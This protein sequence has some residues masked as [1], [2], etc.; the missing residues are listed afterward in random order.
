M[1][2]A[3]H[4][5]KRISHSEALR[6]MYEAVRHSTDGLLSLLGIAILIACG[7]LPEPEN[8]RFAYLL[9]TY[10][11]PYRIYLI[12]VLM[13]YALYTALRR[14]IADDRETSAMQIAGLRQ[15]LQ[16]TSDELEELQTPR[17]EIVLTNGCCVRSPLVAIGVGAKPVKSLL[18][19][20]VYVDIPVLGL[21]NRVL[22][23]AH[24]NPDPERTIDSHHGQH[25]HPQWIAIVGDP[26]TNRRFLSLGYGDPYIVGAGPH[27]IT[28]YVKGRDAMMTEAKLEIV[29]AA[30]LGVSARLL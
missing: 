6:L 18:S 26:P 10:L 8:T 2:P 4:H 7:S 9:R 3:E 13:I 16:K 14:A 5:P 15:V 30:P 12:L 1:A 19:A 29:F 23:W 27:E 21:R 22:A 28:V 24:P 20:S 11:D 17:A 25:H